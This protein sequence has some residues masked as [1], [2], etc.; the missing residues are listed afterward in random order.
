MVENKNNNGENTDGVKKRSR[1]F[2]SHRQPKR[3]TPQQPELDIPA[4]RLSLNLR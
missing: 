1:L 2:G 3:V 4:R